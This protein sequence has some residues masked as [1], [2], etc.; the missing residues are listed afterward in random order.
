MVSESLIAHLGEISEVLF[1]LMGAMTIVELIDAHQ[2]FSIITDRI[3]ITSRVKLIW[4]LS[5]ITFFL[6]RS[7]EHTSELQSLMRISYAVFCLKKKITTQ[8]L[9]IT[10]SL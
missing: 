9:N 7:E 2:G 6:S 10:Y 3:R 4:V 1:F 5:F 8:H